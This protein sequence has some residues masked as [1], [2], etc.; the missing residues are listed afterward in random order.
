MERELTFG[1]VTSLNNWLFASCRTSTLHFS[2]FFFLSFL[3]S[4]LPSF[5][6]SFS[7][8]QVYDKQGALG[9]VP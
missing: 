1:H 4:F 5:F 7:Y 9:Q 2:S 3:P 6:L 8:K